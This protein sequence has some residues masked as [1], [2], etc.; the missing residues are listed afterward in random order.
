[1]LEST[2]LLKMVILR[3]L[4]AQSSAQIELVM[5]DSVPQLWLLSGSV[6]HNNKHRPGT[7]KKH[8]KACQ[9]NNR[10]S[11]QRRS[12]TGQYPG[13]SSFWNAVLD[14]SIIKHH[15]EMKKTV[16]F[17]LLEHV[18]IWEQ[19]Q[20]RISWLQIKGS[21]SFLFLNHGQRVQL[22]ENCSAGNF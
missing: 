4:F 9:C 10:P 3:L 2:F 21:P 20:L 13:C 15:D 5:F 1:M 17:I 11:R 14:P 16:L 18:F 7:S 22:H 19:T 12:M 6:A 8:S